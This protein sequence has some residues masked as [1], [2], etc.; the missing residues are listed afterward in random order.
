MIGF[1][2]FVLI[3]LAALVPGHVV[4]AVGKDRNSPWHRLDFSETLYLQI[5]ISVL[6]TSF[7]ASF[8][9][10]LGCFTLLNCLIVLALFSVG[11]GWIGVRQRGRDLR[12]GNGK[13]WL[14]RF[15]PRFS[16]HSLLLL[17]ILALATWLYFRPAEAFLV[18][19][20]GG[21][22]LLS[23]IHLAETGDLFA[24]DPLLKDFTP[25]LGGELLFASP[26]TMCW[27][28]FWGPFYLL[29]W[30]QSTVSF[31]FFH[32][33]RLWIALFVL[34]F[35]KQ[36]ALYVAPAFGLLSTA[37]LYFLGRWLFDGEKG[38]DRGAWIGLLGSGLLALNF[39]QIWNVRYPLSEASAQCLIVGC[40][41][42]CVVFALAVCFWYVL[43]HCRLSL[44]SI[45][46]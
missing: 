12:S 1:F 11:V 29:N 35:G 18:L 16:V 19:D 5:L 6:I 26:W 15:T 38:S 46:F 45:S 22:Y 21:V 27:R 33:Y 36:G 28:R 25:A 41:P 34:V 20:D 42:R 10:G 32:F 30:G 4:L 44:S 9:A 39:A 2:R 7:V 8:L 3:P 13:S 24:Y 17:L 14:S 31:G 40:S 23:G 37:G 43:I